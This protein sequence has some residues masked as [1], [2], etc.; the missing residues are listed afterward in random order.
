[1]FLAF[2]GYKSAEGLFIILPINVHIRHL[3]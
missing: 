2:V 1:V 3:V